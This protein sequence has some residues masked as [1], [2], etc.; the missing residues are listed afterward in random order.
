MGCFHRKVEPTA[1]GQTLAIRS[2]EIGYFTTGASDH[3]TDEDLSLPSQ[4]AN[5]T[6]WGPRSLGTP[7]PQKSRPGDTRRSWGTRRTRLRGGIFSG[8]F[9]GWDEW[10]ENEAGRRERRIFLGRKVRELVR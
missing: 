9:T 6:S 2:H 3:P 10:G 4:E 8:R 7:K 5:I 1:V